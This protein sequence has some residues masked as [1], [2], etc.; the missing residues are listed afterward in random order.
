MVY[1]R[2]DACAEYRRMVGDLKTW[3]PNAVICVDL[4][5]MARLDVDPA[6]VS[7]ALGVLCG[8]VGTSMGKAWPVAPVCPGLVRRDPERF[9]PVRRLFPAAV[10]AMKAKGAS[11]GGGDDAGFVPPARIGGDRYSSLNHAESPGGLR[12]VTKPRTS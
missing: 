9:D 3:Q 12:R 1:C 4:D 10:A 5:W 6:A 2:E 11:G 8:I 7:E